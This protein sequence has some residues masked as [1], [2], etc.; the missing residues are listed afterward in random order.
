LSYESAQ[1]VFRQWKNI[2]PEQYQDAKL[3][4]LMIDFSNGGKLLFIE[5]DFHPS[6]IMGLRIA[7]AYFLQGKYEVNYPEFLQYCKD[8]VESFTIVSVMEE[9]RKDLKLTGFDKLFVVLHI[10]EV[11][12]I[13]D[14][15]QE[16][17]WETNPTPK[18]LFKLLM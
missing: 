18:G 4:Y 10:D 7:Y 6:L 9:I 2:A 13:F 5:K 11:Q 15:E 12:F 17:K 14:F 16:Y 1:E 3:L 8:F